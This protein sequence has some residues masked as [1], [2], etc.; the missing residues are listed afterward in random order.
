MTNVFRLLFLIP[1]AMVALCFVGWVSPTYAQNLH[2]ANLWKI[3]S[4]E[5]TNSSQL[6]IIN[7]SP[8]E[9][10]ITGYGALAGFEEKRFPLATNTAHLQTRFPIQAWLETTG[11]APIA[12]L[13]QVNPWPLV[14]PAGVWFEVSNK[15]ES[16]SFLVRLDSPKLIQQ[17]REQIRS[18]LKPMPRRLIAVVSAGGS[19]FNRNT[20]D[21]YRR[22]WS[23][24][25]THVSRFADFSSIDCDGSPTQLEQNLDWWLE[26]RQGQICFWNY[27]VT[28]ELAN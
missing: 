20:K 11:G 1:K 5:H 19:G 2:S 15:S 21:P 24:H 14:N 23:W 8:V 22:A 10:S 6:V 26:A 16:E 27:R 28:R 18:P 4:A 7:S 25:I 17:A 12:L 9:Q 13:P 3:P